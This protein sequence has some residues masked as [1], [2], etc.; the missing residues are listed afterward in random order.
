MESVGIINGQSLTC[1][2]DI[3]KERVEM[4]NGIEQTIEGKMNAI[5]NNPSLQTSLVIHLDAYLQ[6][7][8][9]IDSNNDELT[10]KIEQMIIESYQSHIKTMP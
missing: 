4:I 1:F 2:N 3:R 5:L 6:I 7:L 9:C 10:S 8:S